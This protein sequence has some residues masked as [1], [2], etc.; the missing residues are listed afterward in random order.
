MKVR[1]NHYRGETMK[2][3][4]WHRHTHSAGGPDCMEEQGR[5]L[6]TGED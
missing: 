5:I 1:L 6:M 4:Q 3:V 2:E